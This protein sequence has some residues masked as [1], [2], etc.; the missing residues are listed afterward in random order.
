MFEI[1]YNGIIGA[2]LQVIY[3]EI[4]WT[5]GLYLGIN[6]RFDSIVAYICSQFN[7]KSSI[8]TLCLT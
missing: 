7:T 2:L 6:L 1:G 4:H 3:P 5:D 8:G